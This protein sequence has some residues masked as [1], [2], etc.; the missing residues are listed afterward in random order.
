MFVTVSFLAS[1][2]TFIR[3]AA[4]FSLT[5]TFVLNPILYLWKHKEFKRFF[6]NHREDLAGEDFVR[7]TRMEAVFR[8]FA[9]H[10]KLAKMIDLSISDPYTL[11]PSEYM[12]EGPPPPRKGKTSENVSGI[13]RNS[14]RPSIN[15][16][17]KSSILKTS[18]S[19][20]FP[21]SRRKSS[22]TFNDVDEVFSFIKEK[23]LSKISSYNSN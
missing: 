14:R 11:K 7:T 9:N 20:E 19:V 12:F 1:K 3:E 8:N 6:S 16:S 2:Q 22:V 17:I 21:N 10:I 18:T 13:D 23:K 4:L 15:P 5:I